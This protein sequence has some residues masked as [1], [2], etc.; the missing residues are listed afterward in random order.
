MIDKEFAFIGQNEKEEVLEVIK[1]HGIFLLK[2]FLIILGLILILVVLFYFLGASTITSYGLIII[3]LAILY[4]IALN[5]FRWANTT[6]LLTNQRIICVYQESWFKRTVSEATLT[7]ILFISHKINGFLSTLLNIGSIH[8]RTSGV[9]EEEIVLENIADPYQV[10]QEI[11]EAQKKFAGVTAEI[12]K[13]PEDKRFWK[14]AKKE[15][16]I[17]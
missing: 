17:R 11:V 7:N 12:Q 8:I 15:K 9:V 6:Y 4:I 2:P 13:S 14:A 1:Y 16:I 10:Q 5:W 3:G